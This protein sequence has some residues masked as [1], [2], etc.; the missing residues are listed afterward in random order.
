MVI[1]RYNDTQ[2]LSNIVSWHQLDMTHDANL[3]VPQSLTSLGRSFDGLRGAP[4]GKSTGNSWLWPSHMELSCQKNNLN[5]SND[6]GKPNGIIW[7][8][9]LQTIPK[10]SKIDESKRHVIPSGCSSGLIQYLY[11]IFLEPSLDIITS[12]FMLSPHGLN[13]WHHYDT[14]LRIPR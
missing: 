13:T 3:E 14:T 2:H 12:H 8:N 6:C 9:V 1:M 5:Q 7:A 10:I 11:K 4:E